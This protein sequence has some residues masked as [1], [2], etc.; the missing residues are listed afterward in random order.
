MNQ[1]NRVR[2][3]KSTT[4]YGDKELNQENTQAVTFPNRENNL[5]VEVTP[6]PSLG[7]AQIVT[8]TPEQARRVMDYSVKRSKMLRDLRREDLLLDITLVPERSWRDKLLSKIPA[9]SAVFPVR[10][11]RTVPIGTVKHHLS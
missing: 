3:L 10:E 11:L 6:Y 9:G 5:L 8:M 7:L 2:I 4:A 1:I